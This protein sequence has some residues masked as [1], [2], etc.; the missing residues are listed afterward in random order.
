MIRC[1]MLLQASVGQL[2]SGRLTRKHG[3]IA[4]TMRHHPRGLRRE[5]RDQYT[6]LLSPPTLLFKHFRQVK[7]E[8]GDHNEAFERVEYEKHFWLELEGFLEL[9]RLAEKSKKQDVFL[10]CQCTVGEK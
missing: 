4:I 6:S 7:D 2:F 9:Q 1:L 5:L 10:I 8:T 3:Y